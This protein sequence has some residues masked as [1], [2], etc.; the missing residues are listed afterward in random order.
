MASTSAIVCSL[1][2]Q[3]MAIAA[4][5]TLCLELITQQKIKAHRLI[6]PNRQHQPE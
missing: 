3:A 5:V 2:W 4:Q 6:S 1:P